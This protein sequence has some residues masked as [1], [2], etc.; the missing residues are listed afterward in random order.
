MAPKKKGGKKKPKITGSPDVVR[1]KGTDGFALLRCLSE[2]LQNNP[3]KAVDLLTE[4]EPLF[5]PRASSEEA[6]LPAKGEASQEEQKN[7]QGEG[8]QTPALQK[9]PSK[10]A[11][12]SEA[13]AQTRLILHLLGRLATYF[14]ARLSE[15]AS[16]RETQPAPRLLRKRK[17]LL[18]TPATLSCCCRLDR[19]RTIDFFSAIR[20]KLPNQTS[21]P[22]ATLRTLCYKRVSSH[23]KQ[24]EVFQTQ[25]TSPQKKRLLS[26]T[27]KTRLD[28]ETDQ[29][30]SETTQN[31][32]T[33]KSA[34]RT[35]GT[36]EPLPF[37]TPTIKKPLPRSL[38]SLRRKRNSQKVGWW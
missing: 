7:N 2:T 4:P 11:L 16:E 3:Q 33:P 24:K 9:R 13:S 14:K 34:A 15:R 17:A 8:D 23:R 38:F 29:G 22:R 35:R 26:G 18:L 27:R 25:W 28:A 6:A 31:L 30:R 36:K 12:E 10:L 37:R 1:F 5:V 32:K 21:F 19:L 20:C